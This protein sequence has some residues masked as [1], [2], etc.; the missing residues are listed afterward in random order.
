MSKTR[1][2]HEGC[3]GHEGVRNCRNS[4]DVPL[5]ERVRIAVRCSD[6]ETVVH[7]DWTACP[8][9]ECCWHTHEGTGRTGWA[10]DVTFRWS[11][12]HPHAGVLPACTAHHDGATECRTCGMGPKVVR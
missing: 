12:D 1:C 3:D 6:V 10:R 7:A 5:D 11:S 8:G 2:P 4:L 9:E